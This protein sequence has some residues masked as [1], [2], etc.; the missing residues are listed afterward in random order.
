MRW[1]LHLLLR[2]CQR[3]NSVLKL[4]KYFLKPTKYFFII[5]FSGTAQSCFKDFTKETVITASKYITKS[6]ACKYV[7]VCVFRY[8]E[9][10]QYLYVG[11]SVGFVEFIRFCIF[12]LPPVFRTSCFT[13]LCLSLV[14]SPRTKNLC[15]VPL[16]LHT[17]GLGEDN[18]VKDMSWRTP[19]Q[20]LEMDGL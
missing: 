14:S 11:A 16:M 12:F 19:R 10:T 9:C 5:M 4:T 13:L 3:I 1:E 7:P 20:A 8:L 2:K 6:T 18:P 17:K 15:H